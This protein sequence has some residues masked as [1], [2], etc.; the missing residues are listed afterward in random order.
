M[1]GVRIGVSWTH[2]PG[3]EP[4]HLNSGW[5]FLLRFRIK[6][7]R[8]GGKDWLAHSGFDDIILGGVVLLP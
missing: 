1:S 8:L 3:Q 2:W 7:V 5:Y 6:V 4:E